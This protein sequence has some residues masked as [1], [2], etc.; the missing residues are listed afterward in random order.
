MGAAGFSG[1]S[2]KSHFLLM[3]LP[4]AGGVWGLAGRPP[5]DIPVKALTHLFI[6]ERLVGFEGLD[7][8]QRRG[9]LHGAV[10]VD[11]NIRARSVLLAECL[12]VLDHR[13]HELRSLDI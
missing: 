13:I 7:E 12:E 5:L 11:G 8:K 3:A 4:G 6:E 2:L 9:R 10:K 1:N